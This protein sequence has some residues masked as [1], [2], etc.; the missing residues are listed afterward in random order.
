[1]D[2][3]IFLSGGIVGGVVGVIIMCLMQAT[4]KGDV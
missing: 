4:K 3:L 1:M 2:I